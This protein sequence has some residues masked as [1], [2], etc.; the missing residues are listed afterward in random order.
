[1]KIAM[2][3]KGLYNLVNLVFV[4]QIHVSQIHTVNLNLSLHI[5]IFKAMSILILRALTHNGLF[6]FFYYIFNFT[7]YF[8]FLFNNG[9][10]N[11][12]IH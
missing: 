11:V 5:K 10:L 2:A 6:S 12:Y 9:F 4:L 8:Y 7:T 1:M 3:N